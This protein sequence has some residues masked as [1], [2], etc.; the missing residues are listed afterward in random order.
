[1]FSSSGGSRRHC[2][3]KDSAK[4]Q[5]LYCLS[6]SRLQIFTVRK[7]CSIFAQNFKT[8]IMQLY[9]TQIVDGVD[10]ESYLGLVIA[11]QVPGYG[12]WSDLIRIRR[13]DRGIFYEHSDAYRYAMNNLCEDVLKQLQ[14]KAKL[15]GANAI[16]GVHIDFVNMSDHD[17]SGFM[18]SAQGTAVRL[19]EI[20][21]DKEQITGGVSLDALQYELYK[22]SFAK[23]LQNG[24]LLNPTEWDIVLSKSIT[25]LADLLLESYE[26]SYES[27]ESYFIDYRGYQETGKKTFER[28]FPMFLS[29]LPY[30][31]A[32]ELL[33]NGKD[34][35]LPFIKSNN[36]FNAPK[37]LS[38]AQNSNTRDI[39][40]DLLEAEK[41]TYSKE[42]LQDM[43]KLVDFFKTLPDTGKME[44]VEDG[45]Y[46]SGGLKFICECG[47]KT[48]ADLVYC[49]DCGKNI[50]GISEKQQQIIDGFIGKVEILQSLLEEK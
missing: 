50:K 14:E 31:Q 33:Y 21:Q 34:Y 46:S 19:K 23:K 30:A 9:T 5:N 18:V 24:G 22:T 36:L 12:F 28:F 6:S 35:T 49:G 25:E 32:I 27:Y 45:V 4:L 26:K 41:E 13:D 3:R 47:G 39:A 43:K 48:W 1:M 40:I 8:V 10:I 16:I 38:L 29:L 42:D 17:R 7:K 15:K 20:A 11:T 2:E 37:I 44:E